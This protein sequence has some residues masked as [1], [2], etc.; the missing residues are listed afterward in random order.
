MGDEMDDR[1]VVN[2]GGGVQSTTM[3]YLAI[4]RDSD[5]IRACGGLPLRFVF[6][7][8]GDE[9]DDVY[10]HVDRMSDAITAAGFEFFV[11]RHPSGLSLS[12]YV[13]TNAK[14]VG[15]PPFFVETS[16]GGTVPIRRGCTGDFKVK[17]IK[18]LLV[19]WYG[20]RPKETV[21]QVF[22]ISADES[23]RMRHP[24]RS[25][26]RF[27]YPLVTMGW[28]RSRCV[29]YNAKHGVDAPRSACVFCPFHSA[30][31]WRRVRRNP[32][33][34]SRVVDFERSV[35]GRYME[36]VTF[37]L[38]TLPFIHR[39]RVPIGEVDF[40]RQLSLWSMDDECAGVCGV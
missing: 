23:Q 14:G 18:R 5:F 17:P 28:K 9:P 32:N 30:G 40:D 22:G 10:Q 39:S 35:H 7:D 2:F 27:A 31:E 29:D 1:I 33:E 11:V 20:K 36:G 24:D 21:T 12:E 13:T 15:L 25:W 37:G 34:W 26:L 6:A 3:A 19:E 8:T 38:K 16:D 4:S